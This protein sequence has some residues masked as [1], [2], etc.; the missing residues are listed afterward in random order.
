MKLYSVYENGILK[1]INRVDFNNKKVYLIDDYK[2][3]YLWF[4]A[5]SSEKKK[6]FGKKRAKN[7]ND[8]RKSPAKIQIINQN[9]EFG[10]FLTIMDILKEGLQREISKEK[11][12]ELVFELEDTLELMNAGLELDLEAEITLAAHKLSQEMTS[13]EDLSKRLAELQ[14]ILLK[15]N[16]KPTINE[17]KK[18]TEDIL[19]SSA[20]FEELTWLI[21]E[22]EILIKKKQLK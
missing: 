21:S 6:E 11:R 3:F 10:A 20:T 8:K 22:L 4:G 14:L 9:Q 12:E 19:K 2:V 5:N 1:K 7:L 17:I 16:V 15:E 18:K 13:Y